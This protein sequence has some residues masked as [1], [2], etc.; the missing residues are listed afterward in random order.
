MRESVRTGTVPL[1]K[2]ANRARDTCSTGHTDAA[3]PPRA[4]LNSIPFVLPTF[5]WP[6]FR[7]VLTTPHVTIWTN[8]CE[9][10][11]TNARGPGRAHQLLHSPRARRS[12]RSWTHGAPTCARCVITPRQRSLQREACAL[13]LL[14][15]HLSG[16]RSCLV[17][18]LTAAS[19]L[20]AIKPAGQSEAGAGAS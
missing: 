1:H 14:A 11:R 9:H 20:R 19:E 7:R 4:R 5:R 3:L 10:E 18:P 2:E 6:A 13:P 12:C 8:D 17:P 16:P 15:V